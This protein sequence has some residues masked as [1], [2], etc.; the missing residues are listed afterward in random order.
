MLRCPPVKQRI[1]FCK[2][3]RQEVQRCILSSETFLFTVFM[4]TKHTVGMNSCMYFSC[5]LVFLLTCLSL[6]LCLYIIAYLV[7]GFFIAQ[8]I[9]N[10]MFL[11]VSTIKMPLFVF[12]ICYRY[13]QKCISLEHKREVGMPSLTWRRNTEWLRERSPS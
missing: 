2:G 6:C 11:K 1:V 7:P 4:A 5:C 10:L 8:F 9:L 3:F 12:Y 13:N